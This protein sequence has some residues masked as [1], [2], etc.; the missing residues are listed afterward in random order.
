MELSATRAFSALCSHPDAAPETPCESFATGQAMRPRARSR[1]PPP[2]PLRPAA[3]P[4][5]CRMQN[6]K[7][8]ST[9]RSWCCSQLLSCTCPSHTEKPKMYGTANILTNTRASTSIILSYPMFPV[10]S[11]NLKLEGHLKIW[12]GT[13]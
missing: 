5:T 7:W 1:W 11:D 9:C 3:G 13:N 4:S 2:G 8:Y 6:P 12:I 10:C